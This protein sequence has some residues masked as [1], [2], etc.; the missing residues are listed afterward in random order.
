[1]DRTSEFVLGVDVGTASARAGLFDLAGRMAGHGVSPIEIARPR[2]DHVEQSSDDIWQAC[3]R[4][5]R[6]ALA[7]AGCGPERVIGMSYD[8][9]CSLV[10]LD[11]GDRPVTVS[12]GGEDRWNVIVWMDHR[13]MAEADRINSTGHP[14][15]SYAGGRLSPE[16]EPPKL[17]WLKERLPASWRRAARFLDLADY[18]TY[19]S[20]GADVRSMCTTVCKWTYL[21]HE[22][23]WARDFFE[24]IG[25]ADLFDGPAGSRAGTAVKPMGTPLGGLSAPAARDLGLR[26]GTAV[27]VGIIDAHAG[28]LGLF[29]AKGSQLEG[30]EAPRVLERVLALIGGTSSCHMAVSREPRFIPGIW[31]PYHSAM[32][33][34]MWLTEGGQSATGSLIDH[35]IA[36]S[37]AA[38]EVRRL[39]REKGV[40]VYEVLNGEI[41]RLEADG[42][43]TRDLHLLPYFHGNRSPRADPSLRGVVSGLP[44]DAGPEELARRYLAAIQAIAY[45]TRHI[46][47]SLNSAGYRIDTI[48]ACGGGTKNPV[49]LREHADATGC[50]LVLPREPEAVLL[51]AALLGAVA[52]GAYPSVILAMAAMGGSEKIIEPDPRRR[53]F[54]QRKY[55]VFQR[56]Y[57]HF[58]ELRSLM[59]SGG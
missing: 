14:V 50:R 4:A 26:A 46:I 28:G 48:L 34:G 51:G 39:A 11:A 40:T 54:H 41:A 57:E 27:G 31:G 25:L 20:T 55:R 7:M 49:W 45:G 2:A 24:K 19:R 21:G 16:M 47:E 29:A 36:D 37:A 22:G 33:P 38:E 1:M 6:A 10:A 42:E 15:L 12:E 9:T 52:A 18:L 56:M 53:D 43:A 30:E 32:V 59:R 13:A 58:L 5:V 23:R 35:V 44:L 17:L 8:A 3:G